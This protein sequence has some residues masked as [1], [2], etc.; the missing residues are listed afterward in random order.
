[1]FR[2]VNFLVVLE[3]PTRTRH[4]RIA[5]L[6]IS[7]NISVYERVYDSNSLPNAMHHN[8]LLTIR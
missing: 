1:M 8:N 5:H 6:V 3:K 4:T 2:V 7:D